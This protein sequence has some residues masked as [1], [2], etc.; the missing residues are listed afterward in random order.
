MKK[1]LKAQ[2]NY[3]HQMEWSVTGSVITI[4]GVGKFE[5]TSELQAKALWLRHEKEL[6]DAAQREPLA[7]VGESQNVESVLP[8]N[9]QS[10]SS[11]SA[12]AD[13][14]EK[15]KDF[16]IASNPDAVE[17]VASEETGEIKRKWLND[18]ITLYETPEAV[19]AFLAT[20][21]PMLNGARPIDV[22]IASVDGEKRVAAI[23]DQLASG[24][25]L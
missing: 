2:G 25:Y 11:L 18:L 23:V 14:V 12:S 24:A 6:A 5:L 13:K 19:C 9:K 20:S 17:R 16:A 21:H 7:H 8:A 3:P 10:S 15:E 22:V 1:V 4:P